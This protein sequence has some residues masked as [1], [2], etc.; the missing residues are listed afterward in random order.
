MGKFLVDA[1]G[2]ADGDGPERKRRG[3]PCADCEG[4]S[5]F[6]SVTTREGS[7]FLVFNFCKTEV[8]Y[9]R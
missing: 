8:T 6:S 3:D 1:D 7:H 5:H 9:Q 2:G 4:P